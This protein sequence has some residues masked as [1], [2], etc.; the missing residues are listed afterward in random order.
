M[1]VKRLYFFVVMWCVFYGG[2]GGGW[3]AGFSQSQNSLPFSFP[4][5]FPSPGP[6]LLLNYGVVS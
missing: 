3:E 4:S 5:R 2:G 6:L 1:C